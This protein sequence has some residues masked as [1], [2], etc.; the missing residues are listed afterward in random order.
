[1]ADPDL[2]GSA[3][4]AEL[5]RLY[6]ALTDDMADVANR[7]GASKEFQRANDYYAAGTKRIEDFFESLDRKVSGEDIYKA[8]LGD[9]PQ[10]ATKIL[11]LK[12]SLN[13][14]EWEYVRKTFV[15]RMGRPVASAA[16]EGTPGFS[17]STFLT[18]Y[19]KAKRNGVAKAIFGN[20]QFRKDLDEVAKY[21]SNLKEASDVLANPSGTAARG[22]SASVLYYAMG[23]PAGT[24]V[25][26]AVGGGATALAGGAVAA[27][28]ITGGILTNRQVALMLNSPRFVNWLATGSRIPAARLPGHIARLGTIAGNDPE[29]AE[30]L[31]TYA[32]TLQ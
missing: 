13:P 4:R 7:N 14:A 12:K 15:T 28:G 29:L 19:E 25:G 10:S 3:Q 17:A 21:S 2:I 11:S 27:A 6:K 24:A 16:T 32:E 22:L 30:A 26:A 23:L 31:A 8:V 18:N 5:K 1:L 20:G 9:N